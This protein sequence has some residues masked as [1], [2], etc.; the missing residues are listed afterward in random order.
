MQP[1]TRRGIGKRDPAATNMYT[2]TELLSETVF[3]L[4][5]PCNVVIANIIWATQLVFSCQLSSESL[6]PHRRL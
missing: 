5:G 6:V 1:V 2:T 4:L 3:F